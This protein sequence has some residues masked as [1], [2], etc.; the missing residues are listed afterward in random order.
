MCIY[1]YECTFL[2]VQQFT[3]SE[4]KNHHGLYKSLNYVHRLLKKFF[5]SGVANKNSFKQVR[6]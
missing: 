3:T 4:K 5:K 1:K 2:L 6:S